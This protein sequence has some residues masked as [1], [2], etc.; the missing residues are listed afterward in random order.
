MAILDKI[1]KVIPRIKT[2]TGYIQYAFR[3]QDVYMEDNTD[4]ETKITEIDNTTEELK[5][6]EKTWHRINRQGFTSSGS[7]TW[8][9]NWDAN[10]PSAFML[11]IGVA[12]SAGERYYSRCLATVIIPRSCATATLGVDY[13]SGTHQ[14]YYTNTMNGGISFISSTSVKVYATGSVLVELMGWY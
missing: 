10:T 2:A 6:T 8:N 14:A 7:N 12:S 3:A 4:L 13:S 5:N 1:H 11:R 9:L